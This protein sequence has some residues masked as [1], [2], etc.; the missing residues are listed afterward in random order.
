MDITDSLA[1]TSDQLDAIEL[2]AGP[3]IFT[4]E[5][6]SKGNVEQPVNVHFVGFPRVWRPSKG[7]RRVLASCWGVDASLWGGRSVELFYDPEVTFGKER[8]GGTRISRLSHIDGTK[9][10]PLLVTRGKSA[11][12]VVEP[13]PDPSPADRIAALRQEWKGADP[14]RRAVI[15]AEVEQLSG[16]AS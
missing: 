11:T 9:K 6:V 13:L 2:V 14:D 8:L 1:P 15:E 3:R 16:G 12:Y 4:V 10:I 5:K 7:M